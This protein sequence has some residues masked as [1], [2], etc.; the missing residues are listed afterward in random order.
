MLT[1]ACPE[2]ELQADSYLLKMQRLQNRALRTIG[3][4]PRHTPIRDLHRS[5]KVSI[6]IY[7]YVITLHAGSKRALYAA[8]TMLLF[9]PLAKDRHV[10]ENYK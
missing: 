9:A 2:W 1:Y 5:L 7:I 4:L 6:H 8:M 10:T 3:N